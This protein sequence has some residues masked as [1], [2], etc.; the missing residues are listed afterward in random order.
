M[1]STK[2][3]KPIANP[4]QHH[5]VENFYTEEQ[6]QKI[7]EIKN[8]TKIYNNFRKFFENYDVLICPAASVS[9]FPHEQLFV[10]EINEKPELV[11]ATISASDA[12]LLMAYIVEKKAATGIT[13]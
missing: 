4:F 5:W 8:L 9:P 3:N 6:Y 13:K 12:S 7:I 11:I 10:K 1:E 2:F